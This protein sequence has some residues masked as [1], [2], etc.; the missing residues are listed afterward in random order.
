MR[1]LLKSMPLSGQVLDEQKEGYYRS[2]A[3][4]RRK[5]GVRNEQR[6]G[7]VNR[8]MICRDWEMRMLC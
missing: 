1:I 5:T 6:R 8:E 4:F 3:R 2:R 7:D